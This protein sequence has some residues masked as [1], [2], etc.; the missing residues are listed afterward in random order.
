MR[1]VAVKRSSILLIL[2]TLCSPV[3]GS[4]AAE[5]QLWFDAPA[6]HFTQSCPLGNGR[7]GAMVFGGVD[8]EKI[9]LNESGM[10]SGSPQDADRPDAARVLPEVRRLLLQGKNTEAERL[11]DE[12]FTCAGPGS[13]RGS[14][15]REPY[16][17]YQVLGN[18]RLNF[19]R[20]GDD[21]AARA[22]RREFDLSEAVARVSYE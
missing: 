12:N 20:K 22:Y 21:T 16:G 7:L 18:L 2:V 6:A 15:A 11:I 4:A 13:G 8:E 9:V 5:R 10:W 14:G 17:A 3:S 1:F 19:A